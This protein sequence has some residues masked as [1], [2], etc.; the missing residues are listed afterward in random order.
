MRVDLE[1][2][3][4]R[5]TSV[6]FGYDDYKIIMVDNKLYQFEEAFDSY[7]EGKSF[8]KAKAT[9][10]PK[11]CLFQWMGKIW[12][13]LVV[14]YVIQLGA[15]LMVVILGFSNWYRGIGKLCYTDF[16]L[17]LSLSLFLMFVFFIP[18]LFRRI[19]YS[20]HSL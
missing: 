5:N 19:F 16:Y 2:F 8:K 6:S 11:S 15:K 12:T 13:E 18:F 9:R 10:L 14:I 20:P 1:Q 3:P 7:C 17:S 4:P